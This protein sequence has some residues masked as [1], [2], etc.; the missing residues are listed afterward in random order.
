MKNFKF[1]LIALFIVFLG[2]ANTFK[3]VSKF[4]N[5]SILKIA[6]AEKDGEDEDE[7][8]EEDEDEDEDSDESSSNLKDKVEVSTP[9]LQGSPKTVTP[10]AMP[11][12]IPALLNAPEASK[13]DST[14]ISTQSAIPKIN[15]EETIENNLKNNSKLGE[16]LQ[17]VNLKPVLINGQ[18]VLVGNALKSQKLFGLFKIE[19]PTEVEI[20]SL[21]GEIIS[22]NQNLWNS[23]LDFISF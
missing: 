3:L 13:T 6:H 17:S 20:N 21:S 1:I 2:I 4:N 23:F 19:I 5:S 7:D 8:E 22:V 10:T 14:E 11:V 16:S 12:A 18:E 15:L 9:M